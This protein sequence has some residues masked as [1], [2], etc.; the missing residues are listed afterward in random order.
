MRPVPKENPTGSVS[1]S[2]FMRKCSGS[3]D[4][5]FGIL[6]RTV[7]RT[8]CNLKMISGP[9]QLIESEESALQGKEPIC[10]FSL[11]VFPRFFSNAQ[12]RWVHL[13]TVGVVW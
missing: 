2:A 5:Y 13:C 7:T 6:S 4:H 3:A 9:T 1:E 10:E 8:R 12:E 11:I